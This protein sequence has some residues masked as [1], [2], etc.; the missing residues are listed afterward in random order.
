[1][2]HHDSPLHAYATMQV[3]ARPFQVPGNQ[4]AA[5]VLE[6]NLAFMESRQVDFTLIDS[7]TEFIIAGCRANMIRA[8]YTLITQKE[9]EDEV[10]F[11]VLA[12]SYLIFAP[13]RAFTFG[14]SSS[15]DA[16][17]FDEEDF[18]NIIASVRIGA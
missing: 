7:T 15:A 17:Y 16:D 11:S 9:G 8:S 1:M 5:D 4:L 3:T 6:Q 2:N 12:R 14:L 13:G 10:E 18:T